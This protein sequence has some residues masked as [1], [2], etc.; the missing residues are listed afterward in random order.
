MHGEREKRQRVGFVGL[1][2]IGEPMARHILSSGFPTTLWARRAASL[3]PFEGTAYH[4]A[5]SLIGLG[6]AS[7]VVGV[8]VFSEEDVS[9][10]VLGDEGILS[11]MAAGGAILV[12]ST[13]SVDYVVDLARTCA[14]YGVTVL[15]A[16]VSGS[17]QRADSGQL[18][19]MVGG[20]AE[21]FQQVRPILESF[22]EQVEHL[23]PIGQG[24]AMKALNQALCFANMNSSVLA[25]ETVRQLGLD[26][27][28]AERVLHSASGGSF[29]LTMVDRILKDPHFSRLGPDIIAKDF[30]FFDELCRTKDMSENELRELAAR[31]EAAVARLLRSRDVVAPGHD[32]TAPEMR[33]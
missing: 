27:E 1:G 23:G 28:A 25:L 9:E 13:V 4:R 31:A 22:G 30:P 17:R 24:E 7:D 8:C 20:P 5:E 19:V 33:C 10:V 18:T 6:R 15:D 2:D 3:A 16:P 12:H 11:G 32:S 14:P 26:Q 29:G 21:A